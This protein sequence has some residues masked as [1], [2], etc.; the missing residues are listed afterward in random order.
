VRVN[1]FGDDGSLA[2][3]VA[4]ILPAE[5]DA[6]LFPK[7]GLAEDAHRAELALAAQYAPEHVKLWL[8][9]ETPL[10][11]LD[12]AR[13]AGLAVAEGSRLSCL[14]M[15]TNDLAKEMRLRLTPTRLA[16]L[17]SF[18]TVILAARAYGLDALDGVYGDVKNLAG[19]ESEALQGKGLGFDGKTLIHPDQ[20]EVANR[21]FSPSPA[22]I[23]EAQAIVSDFE[24]PE[25]A[26]KAV[27][28]V[29]GQMTERLH[30]E[31]AKRVLTMA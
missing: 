8:M 20:I 28:L 17:H 11:V 29:N 23:T 26:Q 19:F 13:I 10:A 25:N 18:S 6:V 4:A 22:E 3:D 27:I 2:D 15:G 9:I 7:I 24:A 14:V 30:Y 16:L 31:I 5:P 12:I 21:L 1:G